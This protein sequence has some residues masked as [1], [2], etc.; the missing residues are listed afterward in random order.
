MFT[1]HYVKMAGELSCATAVLKDPATAAHEIDR[2]LN[3]MCFILLLHIRVFELTIVA[4]LYNSQPGYIVR[5]PSYVPPLSYSRYLYDKGC[6]P[7]FLPAL[8]VTKDLLHP[9]GIV[10]RY[11]A[12][13]EISTRAFHQILPTPKPTLNS[14]KSLLLKYYRLTILIPSR[15]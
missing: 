9:S 7:L 14:S 8:S 13:K 1:S 2:V 10:I 11:Y 15:R 5:V 4:I 3:C 6:L 12:K